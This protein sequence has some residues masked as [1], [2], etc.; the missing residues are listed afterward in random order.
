MLR[1]WLTHSLFF[2]EKRELTRHGTPQAAAISR[3]LHSAGRFPERFLCS[4]GGL[5]Q[6]FR[7]SE[8]QA[9]SGSAARTLGSQDSDM[10]SPFLSGCRRATSQD[11][12]PRLFTGF[13]QPLQLSEGARNCLKARSRSLPLGMS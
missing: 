12:T 7:F 5:S 10:S 6:L 2:F 1:H 4:L 13:S 9:P 11:S 8:T 3:V